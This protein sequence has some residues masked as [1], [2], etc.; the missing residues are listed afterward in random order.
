M[1][2]R[3]DKRELKVADTVAK[4]SAKKTDLPILESVMI[5]AKDNQVSL[6]A[7]NLTTGIIAKVDG[8]VQEEGSICINAKTFTDIVRGL[9]DD[10][11]SI[12]SDGKQVKISCG[13]SEYNL[14]YLDATEFPDLPSVDEEVALTLEAET[15]TNLIRQT[16]FSAS[17]VDTSKVIH[18]GVKFE[19]NNRKLKVVSTDGFRLSYREI[20]SDAETEFVVPANSLAEV[21]KLCQNPDEQVK[22][23]KANRHISFEVGN[24]ILISRLLEGEF[25]NYRSVLPSYSRTKV[26]VSVNALQDALQRVS[27]IVTDRLASP[28]RAVFDENTIDLQTSTAIGKAEEKLSATV[29]GEKVE[30]GFNATFV[31]DALRAVDREEVYVGLNDATSPIL[32]TP[33]EGDF[34][35]YLIL[36]VRL[37]G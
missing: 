13:V 26:K 5:S 21:P 1:K 37:K 11:I 28:I 19:A 12:E 3:V 7:Y 22:I 14:S 18:T 20:A 30:L 10:M 17:K 29:D 6:T 23:R 27:I 34:F 31:L 32:L 33:T 8:K 9:P 25:L 16:I 15:L 36:P 4:V 24:F 35:V 2:I